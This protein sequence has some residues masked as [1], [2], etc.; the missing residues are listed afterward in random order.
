L[1]RSRDSGIVNRSTWEVGGLEAQR[2]WQ[3]W[4][5]RRWRRTASCSNAEASR[6]L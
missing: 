5:A 3:A 1:L 4:G 6:S 2:G